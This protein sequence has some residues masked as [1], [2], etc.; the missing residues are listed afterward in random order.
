MPSGPGEPQIQLEGIRKVFGDSIVA[1]A[2]ADLSVEDGE[3]FAI[4]GPSGSGKTTVLRMIAGFEQPTAGTIRLGGVDVTALPAR[5]RDVNTVFQEY[6]LF[7]HMTVAQNVEYGM[8]VRGVPKGERRTRTAE[9]LEMVRLADFGPRKPAQLSGGQRQR[10]ALARALVGRPRVL[11]LDE[12]LGALDLKLR[13]Q[14]QVELKAIQREVGITFVIVTHDQDEALTLCDRLA[15]FNDGRIEQVGD[16][17]DVYENPVNRF[18][19][20]F[21]G[22]SNV[23]D[24]DAA[25]ALVGRPGTFAVRPERISVLASDAAAAPGSRTVDATVAEVIY[26][27]PTTRVAAVAASGVL[28]TATVLNASASLPDDLAHGTQITLAW[29]D[30][31]VHDLTN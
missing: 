16:A 13:E 4:L 8:K 29:P 23:L 27:G 22:T 24:G 19:A 31:A 20:D 9:A 14:M 12:P 17:R 3:L 7:P 25:R 28:L 6:A 21:V 30:S 15:V 11:L 10:V 26:A 18:V 5:Q 2:G 1:V